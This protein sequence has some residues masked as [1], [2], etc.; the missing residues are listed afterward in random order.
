MANCAY[1]MADVVNQYKVPMV[2]SLSAGDDLTQRLASDWVIRMART[3]S[4]YGHTAADYA[5]NVLGWRKVA[6]LGMDYSW[7]YETVGAFH[8]VFEELGGKVIQKMWTPTNTVD[9]APFVSNFNPEADGIYECVT[10]ATS[11]RFLQAVKESGRKWQVMGPGPATDESLLEAL[12]D[13]GLGVYTTEGWSLVLDTPENL[14]FRE[15]ARKFRKGNEPTAFVMYS[16][17]T[18]KATIAAIESIGGAVED[19]A[20]LMDALRKVEIKD[21]AGGTFKLDEY[22]ESIQNIYVRKVEKV[23]GKYQNTVLHTYPNVSQFWN[24]DPKKYLKDPVYSRD[25]P[26][27]QFCK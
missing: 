15:K 18:A 27:C 2:I 1:A 12:G 23:N 9:F 7:G 11:I 14:E 5:Y 4:E 26:V 25:Y 10:G 20:K 8:R 13:A 19:K 16:Y 6:T 17:R 24:Y 3:S 22:G 21:V